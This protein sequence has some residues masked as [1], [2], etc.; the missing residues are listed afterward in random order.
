MKKIF[1]PILSLCLAATLAACG[2]G[3]HSSIPDSTPAVLVAGATY[4]MVANNSVLVPAG[5]T[6]TVNGSTT[7]IQGANTT[8][9]TTVG[10][11]VSVPLSAT[12]ASNDIVTTE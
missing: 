10:A 4:T 3:S 7:T 9:N 12:G 2:G 8:T 11:V 5:S 6:V 1:A